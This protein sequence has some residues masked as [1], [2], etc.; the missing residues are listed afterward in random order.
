MHIGRVPFDRA[1]LERNLAHYAELVSIKVDQVKESAAELSDLASAT[2]RRAFLSAALHP[3]LP[4]LRQQFRDAAQCGAAVFA[5][6]HAGQHEVDL[7]LASDTAIRLRGPV[8][9]DMLSPSQWLSAIWCA[10]V[11]ND[12]PSL[13]LLAYAPDELL[14]DSP[15]RDDG[16][17]Y[18]WVHAHRA[19]WLAESG[20]GAILLEALRA[21]DPDRIEHSDVN[22]VI[23]VV[24]P[25]LDLFY[26]VL[27]R[28]GV[29]CRDALIRSLQGHKEFW[30]TGGRQN[31]IEGLVALAPT[32]FVG[33]AKD[34]GLTA[35]VTSDYM[36]ARLLESRSRRVPL[37]CCPY[38]IVPVTAGTEVCP[39]CLRDTRNDAPLDMDSDEYMSAPR[40]RCSECHFQILQLAV[41]C[42][43]CRSDQA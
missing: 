31:T 1:R 5:L 3:E 20:V 23:N 8:P 22:H 37:V 25:T 38:C 28:D 10:M 29:R 30:S 39:A 2:L 14:R 13:M 15:V 43:V 42:A 36:P 33:V 34:R 4:E 24:V 26:G 18:H 21:T 40:K 16:F 41:T 11:S 12:F 7:P 6:A 27:E 19:F 35:D 9:R 32:A 17:A